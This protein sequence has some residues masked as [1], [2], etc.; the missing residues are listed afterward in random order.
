VLFLVLEHWMF[1]RP[2]NVQRH[3]IAGQH[4]LALDEPAEQTAGNELGEIDVRTPFTCK[5]IWAESGKRIG[6]AR[7]H[8]NRTKHLP[9][10]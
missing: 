6:H 3:R 7:Q 1:R 2:Q 8:P 5:P 9:D 4:D 10:H